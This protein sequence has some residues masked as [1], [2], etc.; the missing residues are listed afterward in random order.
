MLEQIA[1]VLL[2]FCCRTFNHCLGPRDSFLCVHN[3]AESKKLIR[4]RGGKREIR[5]PLPRLQKVFLLLG[6]CDNV[7][8]NWAHLHFCFYFGIRRHYSSFNS[9]HGFSLVRL[10]Y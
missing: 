3:A 2:L 9:F 10:L 1:Q 7:S 8:K 5:I 4:Y 6:D